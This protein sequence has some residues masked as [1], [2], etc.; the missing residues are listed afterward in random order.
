MQAFSRYLFSPRG[1]LSHAP[2]Q[3]RTPSPLA[4]LA[5]ESKWSQSSSSSC[6]AKPH[7]P[8]HGMRFS[9]APFTLP[10]LPAFRRVHPF[11]TVKC[12]SSDG[13]RACYRRRNPW[14]QHHHIPTAASGKRWAQNMGAKSPYNPIGL[15]VSTTGSPSK[16]TYAIAST[17]TRKIRDLE[18]Y[19]CMSTEGIKLFTLEKHEYKAKNFT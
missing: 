14:Q 1:G 13:Q 3:G 7:P 18:N 11:N 2:R 6:I 19:L 16:G 5:A 4:P 17:C 9:K 15:L 12:Q 8:Q 10:A